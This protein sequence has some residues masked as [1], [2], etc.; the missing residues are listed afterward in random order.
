[1]RKIENSTLG[2]YDVL[3]E[4]G[5]GGMGTVYLGHD[6]FTGMDVAIKVAHPDQLQDPSDGARYRKM[7]FNEAKV[8]GRLRH[9]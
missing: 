8:A 7:F 6:P 5:R 2:R 9:R 3:R 4:I 1:M